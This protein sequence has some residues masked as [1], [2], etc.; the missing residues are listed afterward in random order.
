MS[1]VADWPLQKALYDVLK[2][3]QVG[4]VP[5]PCYD[6]LPDAHLGADEPP[7]PMPYTVVG[8]VF[9]DATITT[10]TTT[11]EVRARITVFSDARGSKE[12][13]EIKAA[14]AE[15]L[16]LQP[17]DLTADGFRCLLGQYLRGPVRKQADPRRG[18]SIRRCDLEF[19]YLITALP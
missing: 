1:V 7:T 3:V 15:A 18:R 14:V 10:T 11:A 6:E 2:L 4:G 16:H 19:R 13:K 8:E 9:D 5:V 12:A 17:P